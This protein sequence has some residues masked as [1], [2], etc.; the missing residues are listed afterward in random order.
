[1]RAGCTARR[2]IFGLAAAKAEIIEQANSAAVTTR[3]TAWR[4]WCEQIMVL[5]TR[6]TD[7]NGLRFIR[8]FPPVAP[9]GVV[10]NSA[11]Q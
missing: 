5:W 8:T 9:L 3:T 2:E 6:H 4:L 11:S 7:A 1:M 10:P